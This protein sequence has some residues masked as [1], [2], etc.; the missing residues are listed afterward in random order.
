MN[1]SPSPFRN[2]APSP[3]SALREQERILACIGRR[4]ELHVLHV[5]DVSAGERG[6]RD[7]VASRVVGVGRPA[8][9]RADATGREDG[10]T[11][12]DRVPVGF[13]VTD[14]AVDAPLGGDQLER[15]G[16][17]AHL[18]SL[19]VVEMVQE[20]PQDVRARRGVDVEGCGSRS[21]RP[22]ACSRT[23]RRRSRRTP[24]RGC[25]RAR[26]RRRRRRLRRVHRRRRDRRC[27]R[28]RRRCPA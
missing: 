21:G 4:M 9:E 8:V 25:R 1:R 26:P 27:R 24:P 22:R 16:V 3:R 7:A 11:R 10:R 6:H 2:T 28:W 17:L 13:R 15:G 20:R 5:L 18:D 14:D 23:T 12:V 19:V